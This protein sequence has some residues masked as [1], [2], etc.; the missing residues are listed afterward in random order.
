MQVDTS[1][2]FGIIN[3]KVLS[4]TELGKNNKANINTLSQH[5]AGINQTEALKD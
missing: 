1:H 4:L 5:V 3:E 2:Q